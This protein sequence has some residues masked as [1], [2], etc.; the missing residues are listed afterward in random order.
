MEY[1]DTIYDLE[2]KI[3]ELENKL[4]TNNQEIH[5]LANIAAVITSILDQESV[6]TVAMEIAIRQVAG[7]VGA[8]IILEDGRM[9]VK[10]AW[11]IDADIIEGYK[12]KENMDVVRYC[13]NQKQ[14][15][16]DNDCR[17]SFSNDFP[18]NNLIISPLGSKTISGTMIIFNKES[19]GEFNDH[20]LE[21]MEMICRFTSVSM[22]NSALLQES[23][24]KQKIE[25]ELDL[26]QQVQT[27]L[28]PES[29][30]MKGIDVASTY[31]PARKVGGDYYEIMPIGKNKMLFMLGDVA[32]KG[33]PAALV[34]TSVHAII[35]ANIGSG[36]NIQVTHLMAQLND[37]LCNDII[38]DR[39]MFLT[40]F[41]GYIDLDSGVM[42]Y[43]N[44]G[45]PPAFY[46]RASNRNTLRLKSKATLV[47]QFAGLPFRSS[48]IK[49]GPG[50]RIFIYSDG[51]NEAEDKGGLLYGL[52]RLEEF[53]K[54][55]IAFDTKRFNQVVKEE[56]DR[57]RIG[58]RKESTD[59]FTTLVIDINQPEEQ[60]KEYDFKYVSSLTQ[61]EKLYNDLDTATGENNLSA[62][63]ANLIKVVISEAFTNA[64]IHAHKNDESKKIHVS[65]TLNKSSIIADI[66]DEG[67]CRGLEELKNH[68]LNI[69]PLAESG[70]GLGL[71]KELADEVEFSR[72]PQGGL[73]VRILLKPDQ[74]NIQ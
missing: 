23:L 28:L 16:Y 42:E 73:R 3:Y 17:K 70:R 69:D 72:R 22:E 25:Q 49:I 74:E 2:E 63:I 15:F 45:H 39:S 38:K 18:A 64:V 47:G 60:K 9:S 5:D 27:T 30:T 58:S 14:A 12:Y 51:I 29:V 31:I 57:Y 52:D 50:D 59:D 13:L 67:T 24:E 53:F 65:L 34:M 4:E 1:Q 55:G 19:G 37:I 71:I 8:V 43:C 40:M 21:A 44:G 26:A 36:K 10:V 32:N 7:E 62:K 61:L 48:K 68:N 20:D 56:I 33:I 66:L 11:G 54:A 6:L 35:H 46:Y 41:M